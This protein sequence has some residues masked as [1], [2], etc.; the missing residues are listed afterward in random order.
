MFSCSYEVD[1]V[2]FYG[3]QTSVENTVILMRCDLFCDVFYWE[4]GSNHVTSN[5]C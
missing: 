1:L 2:L 5:H 4:V 3:N